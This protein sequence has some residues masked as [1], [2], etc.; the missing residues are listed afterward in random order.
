MP[1]GRLAAGMDAS[2]CEYGMELRSELVMRKPD[3]WG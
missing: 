2:G 1:D 3:G